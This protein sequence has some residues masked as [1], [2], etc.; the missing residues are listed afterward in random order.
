MPTTNAQLAKIATGITG[1]DIVTQGGIPKGR[2]T[3]VSGT[4]GS[5]KTILAIQ[6]LISGIE[7]YDEG[8]VFVTFEEPPQDIRR[9]VLSFGWNIENYEK[10][11]KWAFVDASP[12]P[13]EQIIETGEL[14]LSALLARIE[15]A[16]NKTN[17]RRVSIDSIGALFGQLSNPYLVRREMQRIFAGLKV[18]H[19][20]TLI[21]SE[22]TEEYGSIARHGVEEFAA[23]NVMVLRNVLGEERRRR[24][25]EVLKFRGCSHQKGEYPFTITQSGIVVLPLSAVE[26]TQRSSDIRINTGVPV[27]DEMCGGG[28]YR[29]A[30]VLASGATGTGKTLLSTTFTNA[31]CQLGERVLMFGLEESRDQIMR[32][33][34]GWNMNL[35]EWEDAGLLKIICVYPEALGL[36]DHLYR[37]KQGVEQFRPKR[38][39]VDSLSALER[40]TTGKSY[41][42]FVIGITSYL[43]ELEIA[44]LFTSVTPTLMGGTSVTEAHISTITDSIILMRYVEI[45]GEMR[46]GLTVLKMRGSKHNK[47][48]RE[49]TIDEYGMHIGDTFRNVGGILTS[50]PL[51]LLTTEEQIMQGMFD[52]N[53]Q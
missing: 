27:L 34:Q 10:A 42:E 22:R 18:L 36:E 39:V 4:A 17:A 33:A 40:V 11:G 24:T 16:V 44:G 48:I 29:D 53:Q 46:R 9:N 26:L 3:L 1:L 51:Q 20:T 32:N 45:M 31:G 28:F 52:I 7:I 35:G 30:I 37:I 21:T 38:V 43:K 49:F 6:Y 47:E 5:A 13:G 2:S 41:R 25:I 19:V 15:N 50:A 8:V 23:D 12:D 14:D